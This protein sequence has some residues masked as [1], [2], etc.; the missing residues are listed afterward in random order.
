MA[1]IPLTV[2]DAAARLRS[3]E[4]SSVE[5][6]RAVLARADRLDGRL[7]TYLARFD[8]R[9]LAAAAAADAELAAG[10]DRG[11]LHG[12]PV[13]VKDIL[14]AREGPTTAQ[15]LVLDPAWGAGRDAPVVARLRSAGAVITGKTTTAEFACGMPDPT[16]PFP[17][18]RNPWD[19][20]AY[21]G[22]SSSGTGS[23]V[24]AGLFL[25]GVGTDTGGSIR[26]PAAYCGISGLKATFGRVPKSGCA[27]LGYSLDHIGP[28][29]R[30]AWD[31]AAMLRAMAGHHPSDPDSAAAP[32]PDY[33]GALSANGGLAGL[34]VGVDR[35]HHFPPDADPRLRPCFDAA[36]AELERLGAR[37]VDVSLP[38][39]EELNTAT[40]LI[41]AAEG[42]A[43][44][45]T[46]LNE[47]W[48]DYFL[49]S[50]ALLARGAAASGADVVQAHRVRRV[51][52]RALGELFSTVD[53]V[54][55]PAAAGGAIAYDEGDRLVALDQLV[56]GIFTP[57]WNATGSPALVVP[58]GFSEAGLP[59]SL[60]VAGRPFEEALLFGVGDAYQRTTDW[61]LR[62]PPVVVELEAVA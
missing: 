51:A 25:A 4:L 27:P 31:C 5:L 21:P 42:A 12:V 58:M 15:S 32:V 56:R 37:L 59:L 6:T 54:V 35:E 1:A 60:Q 55:G 45:R 7:G 14:A 33:V 47:R 46:D 16:K 41:L 23:G 30:S 57:Y 19:L 36:L 26:M 28:L 9:A 24:A 29:A 38:Y 52:Q 34:R 39:W 3:G 50:R 43:Y 62:V 22:G 53:V 49:A 40:M 61:H 20:R 2:Q 17:I 48:D 8:E 44:H 13:A 11:P 18:P 10:L